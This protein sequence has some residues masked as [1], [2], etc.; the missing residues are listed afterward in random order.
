VTFGGAAATWGKFT[1]SIY[2]DN[3]MTVTVPSGAKTGLVTVQELTGS[4]ISTLY[5]FTI[6]CTGPLCLRRP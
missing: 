3:F 1:V 4:N 2:S 5:N 6:A